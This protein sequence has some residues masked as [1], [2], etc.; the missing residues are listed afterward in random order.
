MKYIFDNGY[1]NKSSEQFY[2]W[3]I[4]VVEYGNET[5]LISLDNGHYKDHYWVCQF[6]KKYNLKATSLLLEVE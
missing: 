2:K 6:I 5:L 1:K 4:G 3:Y